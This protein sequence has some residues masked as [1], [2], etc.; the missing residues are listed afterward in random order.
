MPSENKIIER[1][2]GRIESLVELFNKEEGVSMT[3]SIDKECGVIRI[4][5]QED[6]TIVKKASSALSEVLELSYA[7]SEHHPYWSILYHATEISKTVLD[8]WDSNLSKD[9]I[10]EMSWR[11]DKIRVALEKI[12]EYNVHENS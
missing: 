10:S 3:I 12:Y 7:T 1:I 4:C 5:S 9:A 11:A 8:E 6:T 2:S